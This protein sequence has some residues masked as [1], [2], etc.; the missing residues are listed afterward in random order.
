MPDAPIGFEESTPPDMF[1]GRS[2]PRA[3]APS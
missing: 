1:T 2:P 3:V